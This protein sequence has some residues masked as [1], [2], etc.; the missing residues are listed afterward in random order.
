MH[1]QLLMP[2]PSYALPMRRCL[3][4]GL[5]LALGVC[6]AARGHA[7]S[8]GIA[9]RVLAGLPRAALA[10]DIVVLGL[11]GAESL[12]RPPMAIRVHVH[13]RHFTNITLN[14]DTGLR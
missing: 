11:P 9:G 5:V 10:G 4:I 13:R 7:P 2:T 6:D 12:P 8:S 14:Y 1:V 3:L